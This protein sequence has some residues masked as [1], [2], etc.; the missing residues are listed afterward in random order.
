MSIDNE[1]QQA[2]VPT[3]SIVVRTGCGLVKALR[4]F[5]DTYYLAQ[6]THGDKVYN[7]VKAG[8]RQYGHEWKNE[9]KFTKK[10]ARDNN[11]T[12][13]KRTFSKSDREFLKRQCKVMNMDYHLAKR[14]ENLEQLYDAKYIKGQRLSP[15]DDDLL[16]A[17]IQQEPKID[18]KGQMIL[19]SG[20]KPIM[21]PIMDKNGRPSLL[22]G[23]YILTFAQTDAPKWEYVCRKL[24]ARECGRMK[25]NDKLRH[26]KAK[27]QIKE[28]SKAE[29]AAGPQRFRKEK[30]RGR[31]R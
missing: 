28:K 27:V 2:I 20:G 1:L 30:E 13:E 23:D 26:I 5:L 22:T 14:P 16:N 10:A 24:E 19:G 12:M 18:D 29:P 8:K 11:S 17:F 15:R 4:D 6:H 3:V 21:Q 9:D 7:N 31:S 25:L